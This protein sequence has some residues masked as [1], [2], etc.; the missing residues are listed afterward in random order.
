MRKLKTDCYRNSCQIIVNLFMIKYTCIFPSQVCKT[1]VDAKYNCFIN[2]LGIKGRTSKTG[3][4][5]HRQT[6]GQL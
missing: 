3:E 1:P 4:K 6:N 5:N 2:P